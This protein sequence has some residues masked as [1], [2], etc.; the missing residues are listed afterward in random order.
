[1]GL[2]WVTGLIAGFADVLGMF[3]CTLKQ[4]TLH[5]GPVWKDTFNYLKCEGHINNF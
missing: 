3:W 5:W 2:T 1:M 4:P